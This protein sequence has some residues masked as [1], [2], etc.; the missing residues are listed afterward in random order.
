MTAPYSHIEV[1]PMAGA[2][3]ADVHGVDLARPLDD[4]I[5]TGWCCSSTTST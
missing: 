4:A 5:T 1:R 2:L 3:G